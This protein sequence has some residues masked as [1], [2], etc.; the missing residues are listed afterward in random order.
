P[1]SGRS[2]GAPTAGHARPSCLAVRAATG[3]GVP[4][5]AARK[6][7]ILLELERLYNHITDV[8]ALCNDVGHGILHAHAQRIREQ[9]LRLNADVT[10]HRLLR[11]GVHPGGATLHTVP[12]PARLRAV[13]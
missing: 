12:E 5:E 10:G 4:A 9:L 2:S 3:H 7:A 1:P 8:G 6:R 11:G 13:A